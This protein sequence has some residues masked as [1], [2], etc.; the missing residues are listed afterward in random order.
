[1]LHVRVVQNLPKGVV[2]VLASAASATNLTPTIPPLRFAWLEITGK[3]QLE[4]EHCYAE[5]GPAGTHGHMTVDDWKRVIDQLVAMRVPM[6]QF[7]G[8][9]PTL[10]PH[11]EELVR[12]A[13]ARQLKVEIF[14]NLVK[15]TEDLLWLYSN[16]HVRLAT[17]YY[18]IDAS[19][20][21]EITHGAKA[22]ELTTKHIRQVVRAGIPLRAGIIDVKDGQRYE[23]AAQLLRAMGVTDIGFDRLREVGR[24]I[25]AGEEGIKQLCGNCIRGVIAISPDGMV[26]PCVFSR[27][28][29]IGSVRI[30]SLAELLGGRKYAQ[31]YARLKTEFDSREG[32]VVPHGMGGMPSGGAPCQPNNCKPRQCQPEQGCEPPC[33]PYLYQPGANE[34]GTSELCNPDGGCNPTDHCKPGFHPG[35]V[36]GPN[37]QKGV[38]LA[39]LSTA[40]G[41][42][43][44]PW[45]VPHCL[46]DEPASPTACAPEHYPPSCK[47]TDPTPCVPACSPPPAFIPDSANRP[48]EDMSRPCNPLMPPDS[49][50]PKMIP[51]QPGS[52][53]GGT[54]GVYG[55]FMSLLTAGMPRGSAQVDCVPWSELGQKLVRTAP[56]SL[57]G[58]T[59]CRPAG[60][61]SPSAACAPNSGCNPCTPQRPH[62]APD[63]DEV[64][65]SASQGGGWTACQPDCTP[66]C[67][68]TFQYGPTNCQPDQGCQPPCGPY[69]AIP[70]V[71]STH[72]GPGVPEVQRT[73][74][75]LAVIAQPGVV[76]KEACNPNGGGSE[77]N[78]D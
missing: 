20:H 28:L 69:L 21:A 24:G 3:C 47:P 67:S 36:F 10:H 22:H 30:D 29:P 41:E 66:L 1:V 40:S 70:A 78:P 49:C 9:E 42:R 51:C 33:G 11:F 5:S 25:R 63:F 23:E 14:T 58:P 72:G 73:A 76:T 52:G 77:C 38:D 59:T 26:W 12:Y 19:D 32:A 44:E 31:T 55:V 35:Y 60:N 53:F 48:S 46:P 39:G 34:T 57:T 7:I 56:R 71:V 13:L 61:P 4:C 43:C 18:T 2:Q 37:G 15:L 50:I 62:C 16:R 74:L 64:A 54:T 65:R 75:G 8:G 45:C 68:P 6:I 27:F 17:S